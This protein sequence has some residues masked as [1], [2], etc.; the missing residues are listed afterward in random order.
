MHVVHIMVSVRVAVL[1]TNNMNENNQDL[2]RSWLFFIIPR[3]EPQ[4]HV[5]IYYNSES[6]EVV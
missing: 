2:N 1:D 6:E 4:Y 5:C 3:N